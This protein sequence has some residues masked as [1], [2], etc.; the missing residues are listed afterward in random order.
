MNFLT[1]K[2]RIHDDFFRP[3]RLNWYENLLKKTKNQGY[4]FY[5]IEEFNKNISAVHDKRYL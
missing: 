1:L 2:K 4:I 3:S 5:T